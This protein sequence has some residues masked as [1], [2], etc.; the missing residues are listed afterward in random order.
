[1]S[2]EYLL[3]GLLRRPATPFDLK[4]ALEDDARHLGWNA[5]PDI[6]AALGSLEERGWVTVERDAGAGPMGTLARRTAEGERALTGWL[7]DG[8]AVGLEDSADAA[9]VHVLDQLGDPAAVSATLAVWRE[10]LELWAG[11][12]LECERRMV[13]STSDFPDGLSAEDF[14]AYLSIKLARA[15]TRARAAWCAESLRLFG[16]REDADGPDLLDR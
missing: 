10:R 2:A 5:L 16:G 13:A 11:E 12:L 6:E 15:T 9:R 14:Q 7:E 3:L 1:M 8:A 4:L